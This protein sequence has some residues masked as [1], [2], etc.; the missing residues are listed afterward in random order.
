MFKFIKN[1][2]AAHRTAAALAT[3]EAEAAELAAKFRNLL[4]HAT[5]FQPVELRPRVVSQRPRLARRA[6]RGGRGRRGVVL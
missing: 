3:V 5:G 2:L 4:S 6:A 1:I